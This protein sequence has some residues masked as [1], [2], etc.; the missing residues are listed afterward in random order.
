MA[1]LVKFKD[2]IPGIII[3]GLVSSIIW[4][5]LSPDKNIL[6][7]IKNTNFNNSTILQSPQ[8]Y[9]NIVNNN[10]STDEVKYFKSKEYVFINNYCAIVALTDINDKVISYT[11]TSLNTKF[12][13]K[14][15]IKTLNIFFQLG[16][17]TFKEISDQLHD[18]RI[19][20]TLGANWFNYNEE[21]SFGRPGNYQTY[22][23]SLN[24]NGIL[25]EKFFNNIPFFFGEEET[26]WKKE[27]VENFR[28]HISPNS[29][30]ITAPFYDTPYGFSDYTYGPSKQQMNMIDI[31]SEDIKLDEFENKLKQ[32]YP[33]STISHFI[34][35]FGEPKFVN[36]VENEKLISDN[37]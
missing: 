7:E 34:K 18:P 8:I 36:I 25:E 21:Y 27:E 5:L 20:G 24:E 4:Y 10:D 19:S 26:N 35:L 1:K 33:E 11:I 31:S 15:D 13:P 29:F 6:S 14:V 30:T 23:F 37:N 22:I 9:G 3:L 32:I 28:T 17:S 16:V 12:K 2:T